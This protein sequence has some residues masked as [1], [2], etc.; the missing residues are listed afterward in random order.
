[1]QISIQHEVLLEKR[2]SLPLISFLELPLIM[3]SIFKMNSSKD[4]QRQNRLTSMKLLTW[5]PR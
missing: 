2:I 1:M 5:M 4:K 3:L